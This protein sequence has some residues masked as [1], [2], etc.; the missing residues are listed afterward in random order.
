M[1]QPFSIIDR[2]KSFKYA[3]NGL[4]VLIRDE[5]NSRIHLVIAILV[6]IL[7]FIFK[8]SMYEWIAVCFAIGFV[9]TTEIINSALE[10]LADF[11]SPDTNNIIKKVKD[12]SAAGVLISALTAVVIGLII[13][14]PKIIE[15]CF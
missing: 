10:N 13:F 12:L 9:I 15:M 3:F 1:K 4:K 2:L 14:L 7:G 6:I 5:H 8:I 11:V